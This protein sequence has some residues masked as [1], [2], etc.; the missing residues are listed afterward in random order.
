VGTGFFKPNITSIISDMYK[1]KES[2]KEGAYTI[3][4]MRVNAGAF[5]RMMLC[6]YLTVNY[7][8]SWGF[9]S[10]VLFMML[11]MLQFWLAKDL[12]GNVRGKPSIKHVV[13]ISQNINEE[14]PK[15]QE[16][17]EEDEKLNPF[18]MLDKILIVLSSLGG[19]IYLFNDPL[20][21]IE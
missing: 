12:F 5:F 2:K 17:A 13:E 18:T 3:F 9:G 6:G 15:E 8:W 4:Y 1:G 7:D 11:G 21:K 16:E 10:S 14:A 20:E 19:L